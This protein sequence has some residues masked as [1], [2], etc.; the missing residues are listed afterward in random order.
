LANRPESGAASSSSAE[1]DEAGQQIIIHELRILDSQLNLVA[2]IVTAPVALADIEI[3]DIG[4]E[5][6]STSAVNA[7]R[8]VLAELSHSILNADLP[9]LDL[10]KESVEER[11]EDGAQRVEEA[12]EDLGGRLR[13]LLN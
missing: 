5:G 11:I 13:G 10:L 9:S 2:A 1:S 8:V 12:V 3:R 4:G 6:G 7:V